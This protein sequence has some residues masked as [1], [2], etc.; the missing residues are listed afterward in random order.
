MY[1]MHDRKA[2]CSDWGPYDCIRDGIVLFIGGYTVEGEREKI[3]NTV[4]RQRRMK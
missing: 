1:L 4:G 2:D 3:A